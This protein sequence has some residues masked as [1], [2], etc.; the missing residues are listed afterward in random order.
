[1]RWLMEEKNTGWFVFNPGVV[2]DHVAGVHT[3]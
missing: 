1:M 3:T 2:R